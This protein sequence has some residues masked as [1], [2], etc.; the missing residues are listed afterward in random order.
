M[1]SKQIP[2]LGASTSR[3][4]GLR[5]LGALVPPEGLVQTQI[6]ARPPRQPCPVSESVGQGWGPRYCDLTRCPVMVVLRV[7]GNCLLIRTAH[8]MFAY[9]TVNKEGMNFGCVYV[10]GQGISSV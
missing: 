10:L 4:V 1:T 7:S 8:W 2:A 5:L 6:A 3:T 9:A